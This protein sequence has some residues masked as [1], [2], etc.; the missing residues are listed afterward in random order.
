MMKKV[1][2]ILSIFLASQTIGQQIFVDGQ[3]ATR[4][5]IGI[6]PQFNFF[7]DWSTQAEFKSGIGEYVH[8]FPVELKNLK[9]GEKLSALQLEMMVKTADPAGSIGGFG[10]KKDE[11]TSFAYLGL[12]E[13]NEFINF[14]EKNVIPNLG[15]SL[16]NKS[17]E[18]IFKAKEMVF[19]YTV[20]EKEKRISISIPVIDD[21]TQASTGK[22]LYFW[23]E[24]NVEDVPNLVK[25][26]KIAVK[27]K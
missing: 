10:K 15:L 19:Y 7:R 4:K 3:S 25:V 21:N 24:K 12:D 1:L 11:T 18:F 5:F 27:K 14:L 22:F 23:T 9:T 8:F 26:L 6:E 20:I 2:T 16:N 17:S 13:V